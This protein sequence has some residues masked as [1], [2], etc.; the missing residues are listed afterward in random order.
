MTEWGL[1]A[2]ILASEYLVLLVVAGV[3]V[4]AAGGWLVYTTHVEP[5]V[6]QQQEVQGTWETTGGYDHAATVTESTRVFPVGATLEDRSTY[7]TRVTPELDGTFEYRFDA[8]D[9]E[10]DVEATSQLVIRSVDESGEVLWSVEEPLDNDSATLSPGETAA[11]PFTLNVS[12][13]AGDVD[14]IESELGASPGETRVFVRTDVSAAGTAAGDSA[15]H[16][17]TYELD[18]TP[19]GATYQ[20]S[21]GDETEQHQHVEAVTR[22][23]TYGPLRSALGPVLVLVGLTGLAGLGVARLRGYLSV[24]DAERT[25]A[26]F[27]AEREEFDDWISR[28]TV[29]PEATE[30][31]VVEM[32]S[33]ED[34]VDVAVDTDGRVV[35]DVDA[36]RYY[37]LTGASCYRYDPPGVIPS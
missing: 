2:R 30:G 19:G 3:L 21:G 22:E 8:A 14:E 33:L 24:S 20:V 13:V 27:G 34:L 18:V 11:V 1:R 7:Y 9:G 32:A 6:E 29:A 26:A 28:G 16:A 35:E 10:L 37:V 36:G 4:A 17:A 31:P 23:T 12:E 5:G 15:Q 25:A